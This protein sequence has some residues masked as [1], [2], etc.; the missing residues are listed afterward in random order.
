MVN[1]KP[2]CGAPRLISATLAEKPAPRNGT[3]R[4][5]MIDLLKRPEGATVDQI[6]AAT[7]R[8]ADR[9]DQRFFRQRPDRARPA[10]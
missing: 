9:R 5:L 6:A 7:G 8:L 10:P 2:S 4:A 3:K 1:R